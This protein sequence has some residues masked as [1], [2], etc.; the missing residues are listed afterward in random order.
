MGPR[1]KGRKPKA[2]HR[3]L[4]LRCSSALSCSPGPSRL[5]SAGVQ[6]V[7]AVGITARCSHKMTTIERMDHRR[8]PR[9]RLPSGLVNHNLGRSHQLS[10]C[11]KELRSARVPR[12]RHLRISPPLTRPAFNPAVRSIECWT[13]LTRSV[14]RC[15]GS[16]Q[17]LRGGT[18]RP[19]RRTSTS[20]RHS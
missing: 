20:M 17:P 14:P 7:D 15:A 2:R 5:L 13:R 12:T 6:D 3:I 16:V 9:V 8:H 4:I 1:L 19:R 10:K 18:T 11:A